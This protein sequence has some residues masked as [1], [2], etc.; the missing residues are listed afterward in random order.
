MSQAV[1]AYLHYLSIFVLFALLSIEHV[2]FTPQPTQQQALKLIRVDMF[3]GLCAGVVVL[4]GLARVLW[5]G[6]GLDYYLH[7]TVF[8]AKIGLFILIGLLSIY[9]TV[10]FLAWR[11]PVRAGDAPE[12]SPGTAKAMI[13]II[14]LELTLL[15]IIPLLATLMARGIGTIS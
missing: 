12:V 3:Y 13:M 9:P 2:L 15:I 6:K 10:K 11:L 7:N 4:T 14:R 1:A 5:Y 8:H